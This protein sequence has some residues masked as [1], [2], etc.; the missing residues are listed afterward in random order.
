MVDAMQASWKEMHDKRIFDS[1][2]AV[3]ASVG[4]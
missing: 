2:W 3:I 4:E 1:F